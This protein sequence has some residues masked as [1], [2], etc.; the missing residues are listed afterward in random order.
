MRALV[1]FAV[2][3]ALVAAATTADARRTLRVCAD[4][5]NL[6]FSSAKVEGIENAVARVVADA[7][8]A[9]LAYTWMPQRRGFVR[10]TLKAGTCDVMMAALVGYERA[11]TTEPYYRSSYVFVTRKDRALA[12]RSFDDPKLREL[13]IGLQMIGDD[14]ANTPP[15]AALARRGLYGR[16]VGYSV[17]GDYASAAPQAP[18]I[19]AV[20]DGSVDVAIVWGPL[21]GYFARRSRVPLAIVPVAPSAGDQPLTFA[22]A[23]GVRRNDAALRAEL[24]GVIKKKRRELDAVL[25]RFGVPLVAAP[26]TAV[27][28][29]R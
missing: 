18:I 20:A 26:A 4:P 1:A 12:L 29:S 19:D 15:A 17:Y 9:E 3:A 5:N 8:D 11:A 21:A 14:Y 6:P 24:D 27:A 7:L 13:R 10:N 22:I 28:I 23:M 16:V 25:R 2:A